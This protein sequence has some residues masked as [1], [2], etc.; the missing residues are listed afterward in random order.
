[1]ATISPIIT[2]KAGICD[3]DNLKASSNPP[4][5]TAR[6]TPG[7]L[8]LYEGHE[9]ELIH[10]CWR[11]R[12]ASMREAEPD[13]VMVPGDGS[14]KPYKTGDA[15]SM[16]SP[17]NGRIFVLKF[18][19]SSA[20]HLFWLQSKTQHE[21]GDQAWFSPRDLKLGEIV[22][23]LLQGE[24]VN[25]QEE[26]TNIE[27]REGG[28]DNDD[29][30][31]D[32]MEGVRRESQSGTAENLASGDPFIGDPSN[33]GEESREG[34]AD[35]GRATTVP[36]TDAAV[37][38]QNFLRSMREN[39][40]LQNPQ[41]QAE[42]RLFTTLP[43]LLPSSTTI[44]VIDSADEEY[45]NTLLSQ[46]PPTLMLLAQEVDDVGSVDP[47]S[48]TAKAAMEALSLD[49]KKDILRKVLRSPQ[50]HQ[51]L[52]SLTGAIRDGGLPSIGDALGIP[53]ENGGYIKKGGGVPLGG[54]D[55]VETF[56][57]G[58][59]TSV[60]KE[61]EQEKDNEGEEGKMETD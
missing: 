3:F 42:P 6:P 31:G 35:G 12:N 52:S 14:F 40:A 11:P 38:V 37:A 48:E 21:S 57:N 45:V 26:L 36:I 15:G 39:Q 24:Q 23:Q 47:T 53:L 33:E 46:L 25:V 55:A 29:G 44:P 27:N 10:F 58:I 43:D 34:G 13:L 1:M 49:Q 30:D 8:F 41:A 59:R 16:K 56:I 5:I 4:K 2:F 60:E 7:Y 22:D 32:R 19:S 50:F 61:K 28:Q 20:R 18:Q 51:S 9:D 17:T 54:G